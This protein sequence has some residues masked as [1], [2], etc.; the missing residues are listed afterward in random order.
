PRSAS[1]DPRQRSRSDALQRS[2]WPLPNSTEL[3]SPDSA[4]RS[5]FRVESPDHETAS[6]KVIKPA[7]QIGHCCPAGPLL[8]RMTIRSRVRVTIDVLFENR[9]TCFRIAVQR[10]QTG[11]F[12]SPVFVERALIFSSFRGNVLNF[13]SNFNPISVRRRIL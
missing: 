3:I 6:S 5:N 4:C 2:S 9:R 11:I 7:A 1:F 8:W 10:N 12:R 13:S